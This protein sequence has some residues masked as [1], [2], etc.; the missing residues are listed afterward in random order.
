M[1]RVTPLMESASVFL[2]LLGLDVRNFVKR[3]IGD[4][5]ATSH[6][7]AIVLILYVIQHTV[8]F[9]DQDIEVRKTIVTTQKN[10]G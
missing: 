9:V 3:D 1:Q 2:G 7:N 5:T 10:L 6:V 4:K 8:V